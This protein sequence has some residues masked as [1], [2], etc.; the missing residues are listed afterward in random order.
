MK[1]Q[2]LLRD[3][4][5]LH[6]AI[7]L[8]IA[9][10]I[11]FTA[12]FMLSKDS[13]LHIGVISELVAIIIVGFTYST[14]FLRHRR[15]SA[16]VSHLPDLDKQLLNISIAGVVV[17]VLSPFLLPHGTMDLGSA[18]NKT[19]SIVGIAALTVV[20]ISIGV[21]SLLLL[22]ARHIRPFSARSR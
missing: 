15:S 18:T 3:Y 16:P 21:H 2:Y 20:P 5:C 7:S 11:I 22:V 13:N 10:G 6:L 1:E 9:T 8:C 17:S 19:F 12:V 14:P 4:T